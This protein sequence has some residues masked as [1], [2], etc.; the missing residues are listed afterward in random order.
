MS[1]TWGQLSNLLSNVAMEKR[2]PIIG[3]FELT[4]RCNL[5][6]KMCYVCRAASDRDAILRERTAQEWIQLAKEARDA[7][8]LY[9]LLTG[10]EVFLRKD[11]KEIWEAMAMMGFNMAIF[12]NG[13]L[14][15]PELAKWLGKFPPSQ[16]EIT[17]Y[18][19]SPETY[20]KV[21]GDASGYERA[22]RGIDLLLEQGINV[23]IRTTVIKGNVNDFEKLAELSEQ[24]GLDLGIVNYISPRREGTN[25][26]PE[27][28]RLS[29]KELADFEYNVNQYYF[30]DSE[31]SFSENVGEYTETDASKSMDV[32]Y[33]SEDPF[34][35]SSGKSSFWVTWDG[36]MI[37][38]S[39]MSNPVAF[40][41]EQGF[42]QAWKLIQKGCAGIPVCN[43]CNQCSIQGYCMP[44]P[45]RLMNETGHYDH[46]SSYL[47]QLAQERKKIDYN[48][49]FI[50]DRR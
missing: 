22:L 16:I 11:F 10:G 8:M 1:T 3:E 20:E 9:L 38:C 46:P 33:N 36:R 7:G 25:T 35:C 13:T 6:C 44:C 28:E 15:T 40:P 32:N 5:Q 37:P 17:L 30:H 48:E 2:I 34:Q 19:G 23:Q 45:A 42:S 50:A 43:T 18:G 27:A 12:S 4:A 14:I 49:L 24:R 47:C 41:F 31:I 39:L 21:C 29:P 26:F